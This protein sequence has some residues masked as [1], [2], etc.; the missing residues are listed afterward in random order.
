[1]NKRQHKKK[2]KCIVDNIKRINLK[3]ND[4][5][6]F[7]YDDTKY[8]CDTVANFADFIKEVITQRLIFVPISWDIKKIREDKSPARTLADSE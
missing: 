6:L 1:M 8:G 5:L 4:I 2:V 7:R 3:E